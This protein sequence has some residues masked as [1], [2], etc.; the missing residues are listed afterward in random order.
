MKKNKVRICGRKTNT[1]PTPEMTPSRTKLNSQPCGTTAPAH[2]ASPS[3]PLLIK[4][5]GACAQV[6]TA[7]NIRKRIASRMT[8]PRTGCS[9]TRSSRRVKP[10]GRPG[11]LTAASRIRSASRCVAR[12]CA[13]FGSDQALSA[14]GKPR[15]RITLSIRARRSLVPPRRTATDATTGMPSSPES[16]SRSI[17]KPR[18]RAISNM[19]S[20]RIIGRQTRFSSSASRRAT[21]RFVESA[22]QTRR[23]GTSSPTS[24][25]STMSRVTI[26][27][28]LRA[29]NEYVPGRSISR[30]VTPPGVI[31]R[32]SLRSTVT[33]G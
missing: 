15:S 22:T 7:W 33:P 30:T 11:A 10:S 9:T 28:R 26:S 23:F 32:P 19:L 29:R 5:I 27:S 14:A 12:S 6:K 2:A 31:A 13:A 25:P 1:L 17:S 3:K 4:S 20:A 21:R 8:R 16:R 24:L 18:W